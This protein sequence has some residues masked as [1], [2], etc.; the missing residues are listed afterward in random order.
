VLDGAGTAGGLLIL[1]QNTSYV[2]VSGFELRGFT[3]WGIEL[4]GENRHVLLDD[5]DISGGEA[6]VR[7]TYG[8]SEGAPVEGPVAYVTLEDST[9]SGSLYTAV[10]CTPGPCNHVTLRRVEVYG[11][12]QVGQA[13]YGADGVA[14]SR[15]YP[16]LVEDCY[17]HDNGG[18][19]IDLN[20][21]DREGNA[22]GVVV[23]RN[24]VVR[25]RLNG[26][27]LWAGGRME[28]NVV[29]GQGNAAVWAGTFTSTLEMVNNTVAYNMWDTDY[30]ARNW[31]VVAGYP[32]ALAAPPVALT[33]V[34]NIF[35]FNADPTDGGPT[36]VY[37]GPGVS[38]VREGHN[39]YYSR[40]DGEITAEFVSGRDADFSRAEIA[41]GTW[42]SYSGQGQ[43]DLTADPLFASGWPGV[44]L[45]L[46]ESSP[47]VDAGSAEGAPME[48][49]SHHPR[50]AQPDLGAYERWE[51]TAWVYLPVL[52]N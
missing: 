36:G 35:A 10:D 14:V 32:E 40:A 13:S 27:K 47:A 5:L 28:N 51:P 22:L 38:L 9:L 50:D 20:S 12:G 31:A 23:R 29:W 15:G 42:A 45:R 26:I 52:M 19:G 37:L 41:D 39:L 21:R 33:L 8:E 2:N 6:G 34:N 24:R 43:N 3:I 11:S 7:L 25:N 17:I 16:I 46:Q 4:A 48:D 1:D 44:D 49:A 18:D 30:S